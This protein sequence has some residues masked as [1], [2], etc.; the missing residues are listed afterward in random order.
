[1][2]SVISPAVIAG[3]VV[4]AGGPLLDA[5][6]GG[7]AYA[8]AAILSAGWCY[9][10]LAFC[11]GMVDT[12]KL[13]AAVGGAVSLTVAVLAYYSTKATQGDFVAGDLT[14]TAGQTTYFSWGEFASM[15]SL[16]GVVALVLG[17]LLGLAGW[18]AR[19]GRVCLPLQLLIPVIA[20][21]EMTMRLHVEAPSSSS[22]VVT[23]WEVV[24]AAA[25]VLIG[26]LLA[27]A[28]WT[29]RRSQPRAQVRG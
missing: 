29:K 24:R 1:M 25:V 8:L 11:A 3:A 9:A 12:T 20:L 7:F 13:R 23:A 26:V 22:L 4:G 17:P 21:A 18:M 16:W 19:R 15:T 28:A 10:A 2:L 5:T 6:G 27:Y 14:D